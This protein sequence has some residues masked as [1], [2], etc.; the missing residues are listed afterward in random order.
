MENIKGYVWKLG[1]N[2][3]TDL[4]IPAKYLAI[5]D[6]SEMATHFLE[7]I[8]PNLSKKIRP[9]DILVVGKNFGIGSSREQ[10]VQVIKKV[11]ISAIIAV[12]IA[13]IFYRNAINNGL[14]VIVCS[15]AAEKTKEGDWIEINMEEGIIKNV[16]QKMSWK[17]FPFSPEILQILSKGGLVGF[18]KKYNFNDLRHEG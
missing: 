14:P 1:D 8:R 6:L 12:S 11:G 3:D 7:P 10:A 13:R 5:D 18:L 16:T 9:G 2:V 15:E 17:F 4:I